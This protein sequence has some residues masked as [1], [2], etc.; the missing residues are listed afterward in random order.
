[1]I[2]QEQESGRDAWQARNGHIKFGSISG[3]LLGQFSAGR[4]GLHKAFGTGAGTGLGN[5]VEW[6]AN[7]SLFSPVPCQAL[8][9]Q[10]PIPQS[11]CPL[12]LPAA[13]LT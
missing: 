4:L 8:I 9:F 1:M 10:F 11:A 5:T 6:A 7:F 12:G 2:W 3:M 13:L